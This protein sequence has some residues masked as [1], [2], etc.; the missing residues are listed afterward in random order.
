MSDHDALIERLRATSRMR[1]ADIGPTDIS[2]LLWDAADAVAALSA[3]P[4]D[5]EARR[6]ET[7]VNGHHPRCS[8]QHTSDHV[9]G[10]CIIRSTRA[11][12]A[13]PIGDETVERAALV[14]NKTLGIC[15]RGH[16]MMWLG[17]T[18]TH[19]AHLGRVCGQFEMPP[20]DV[21]GGTV[22]VGSAWYEGW[23][24]IR[25]AL[26]APARLSGEGGQT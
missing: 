23:E 18:W 8:G 12:P 11:L 24:G 19:L 26:A 9:P 14:E 17:H 15:P 4:T 1:R 10:D 16:A 22:A 5:P 6:E 25:D 7:W 20:V 21:Q 3:P 2:Q 13:A